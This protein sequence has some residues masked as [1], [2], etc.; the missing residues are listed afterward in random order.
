M[1]RMVRESWRDCLGFDERINRVGEQW[2]PVRIPG[3]TLH[4]KGG[5]RWVGIACRVLERT[6]GTFKNTVQTSGNHRTLESSIYPTQLLEKKKAKY[7]NN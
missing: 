7:E 5:F 6:Q 2:K 1:I 3:D 4:Q